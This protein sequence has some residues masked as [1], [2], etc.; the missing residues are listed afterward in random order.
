VGRVVARIEKTQRTVTT[1]TTEATEIMETKVQEER[2]AVFI[3]VGLILIREVQSSRALSLEG[4][5]MGGGGGVPPS[6]GGSGERKGAW[7][8]AGPPSVTRSIRGQGHQAFRG[9]R[10]S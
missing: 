2:V 8:K 7:R 5:R 10:V 9:A 4:R 6:L 3:V 1:E